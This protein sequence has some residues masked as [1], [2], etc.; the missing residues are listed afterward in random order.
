MCVCVCTHANPCGALCCADGA[1]CM[2]S[3]RMQTALGVRCMH[4]DGAAGMF[5]A[6]VQT[7]LHACLGAHMRTALCACSCLCEQTGLCTSFLCVK[8]WLHEQ[9]HVQMRPMH[10]C[11]W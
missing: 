4:A 7:A 3:A 1:V 2:S 11:A 6:C 5:G 9:A 8:I 10:V